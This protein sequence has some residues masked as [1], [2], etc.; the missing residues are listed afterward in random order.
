[1]GTS[2]LNLG[3]TWL[4]PCGTVSWKGNMLV[5]LRA[6]K[7]RTPGVWGAE[8]LTSRS[9]PPQAW[10]SWDPRPSK[11]A[12]LHCLNLQDVWGTGDPKSGLIL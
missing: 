9:G 10:G 4:H 5:S 8:V 2:R 11:H 7:S 12:S 1:M 3:T 6:L